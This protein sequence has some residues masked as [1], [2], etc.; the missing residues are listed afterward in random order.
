VGFSHL[1]EHP[2]TN[3]GAE[4]LVGENG[5]AGCKKA[6][7]QRKWARVRHFV[8]HPMKSSHFVDGSIAGQASNL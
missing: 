2:A 6:E 4:M 5:K 3:L 1:P 7:K 8:L